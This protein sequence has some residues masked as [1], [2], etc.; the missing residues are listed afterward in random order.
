MYS[1]ADMPETI[2]I[3]PLSG[4]LLLPRGRLPLNV[5]EPRYLTMIDA[6]LKSEHRLLGMVQPVDGSEEDQLQAIGC[7]GRITSLHETDDNRYIITLK[8]ISRF[9]INNVEEGFAPYLSANV[10]W[11]DYVDD[12]RKRDVDEGF[13]RPRF[14]E[15]LQAYF[16]QHELDSNW[17]ELVEADEEV[18]INSL[19]TL[20]PFI[21]NEKQALLEAKNLMARRETL[22]A[23]M[24]FSLRADG[25]D[26]LQ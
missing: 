11:Q 19:A 26:K 24:E 15:M 17:D 1:L 2:P 6:V 13:N 25:E 9:E 14:L 12:L 23:L 5:F 10:S 7:A 8:G 4:A 18:L 20:C 22:E 16:D 3:F 21:P